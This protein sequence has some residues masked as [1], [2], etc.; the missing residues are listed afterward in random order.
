MAVS[1]TFAFTQ[2]QKEAYEWAYKY[3]LTTQPSIEAARM[4]SPLTRQAF[5]KMIV[6]YLENVAWVR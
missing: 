6:S 5:S 2:E 1:F 4:N 3:W